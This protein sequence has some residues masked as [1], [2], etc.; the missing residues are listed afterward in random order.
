MSAIQENTRVIT[1]SLLP[2]KS[3]MGFL[4]AFFGPELMM[5]GEPLV[6][7][8]MRVLAKS[9]NGGFWGYYTLSN[10]GFYMAPECD[11]MYQIEVPSNG[12]EGELSA[13]AAGVV[14]TLYGLCQLAERTRSERIIDLYYLLR[15]FASQHVEAAQIFGAID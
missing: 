9:Y 11:R 7:N 12:F 1:A 4:P 14:A 3:R 10:G 2:E 5:L 6:Y 15:D 13:D 8:W